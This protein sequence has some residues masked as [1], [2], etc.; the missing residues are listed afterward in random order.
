MHGLSFQKIAVW[1][2]GCLAQFLNDHFWKY[3]SVKS[4]ISPKLGNDLLYACSSHPGSFSGH[5]APCHGKTASRDKPSGGSQVLLFFFCFFKQI[6]FRLLVYC[7]NRK[8][9]ALE[10]A[11]FTSQR[12]ANAFC[13]SSMCKDRRRSGVYW[14]TLFSPVLATQQK[15]T[16]KPSSPLSNFILLFGQRVKVPA[17]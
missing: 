12:V 7:Q 5:E 11:I 2:V 9:S 3:C 8:Q 17:F 10:A 13:N 1:Q 4:K 14:G 6:F 16:Q 15:R